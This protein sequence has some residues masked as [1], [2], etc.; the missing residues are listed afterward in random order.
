MLD[1][2][3]DLS[4]TIT[5]DPEGTLMSMKKRKRK[6]NSKKEANIYSFVLTLTIRS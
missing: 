1:E 3:L 5:K 2:Q 6:K 4:T